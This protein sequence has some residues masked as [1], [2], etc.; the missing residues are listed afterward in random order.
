MSDNKRKKNHDDQGDDVE[1][2]FVPSIM[3]KRPRGRSPVKATSCPQSET[4]SPRR[5]G[6]ARKQSHAIREMEEQADLEFEDE[7]DEEGKKS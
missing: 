6:R 1:P 4:G 7:D 5:S 2:E 3:K